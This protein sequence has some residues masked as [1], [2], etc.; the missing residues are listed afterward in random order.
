[1]KIKT[2]DDESL[3]N[4]NGGQIF[5]KNHVKKTKKKNLE[6]STILP[7]SQNFAPFLENWP[8]LRTKID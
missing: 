3:P 6:F 2:Y 4:Q 8:N 5:L 7:N 1:M